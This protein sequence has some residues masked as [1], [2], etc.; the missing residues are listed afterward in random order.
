[1]TPVGVGEHH[2]SF[3]QRHTVII[4]PQVCPKAWPET[5]YGLLEDMLEY[6][7]NPEPK[8]RASIL[9]AR[10]TEAIDGSESASFQQLGMRVLAMDLFGR[11]STVSRWAI[12]TITQEDSVQPLELYVM[13]ARAPQKVIDEHIDTLKAWLNSNERT[14]WGTCLVTL[15][16]SAQVDMDDPIAQHMARC[17]AEA[18]PPRLAGQAIILTHWLTKTERQHNGVRLLESLYDVSN[19][20][21]RTQMLNAIDT[22]QAGQLALLPVIAK[23]HHT[24]SPMV[25]VAMA[26]VCEIINA[27]EA[28]PILERLL[29]STHVDVAHHAARVAGQVGSRRML[30]ALKQRAKAM[31]QK[32]DM[33]PLHRAISDIE[34]RH[35]EQNIEAGALSLSEVPGT[36]GALSLSAGEQGALSIEEQ[37]THQINNTA[38][39]KGRTNET[40]MTWQGLASKDRIAHDGVAAKLTLVQKPKYLI[41]N[42]IVLFICTLGLVIFYNYAGDAAALFGLP[43]LVIGL[44]NQGMLT[45][46]NNHAK[47]LVESI[48]TGTFALASPARRDNPLAPENQIVC[49]DAQGES[50]LR[51]PRSMPSEINAKSLPVVLPKNK[52]DDVV[53]LS[54]LPLTLNKQG[55][56]TTNPTWSVLL[57]LMTVVTTIMMLINLGALALLGG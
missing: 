54:E 9:A 50:H 3:I 25:H 49:T 17:D 34:M 1:M 23:Q 32:S 12:K 52:G 48:D 7:N 31:D 14:N 33:A 21:Q 19:A 35:P 8:S 51:Q 26:R 24:N 10:L 40:I 39:V 55:Q 57:F 5:H 36:S 22:S 41:I 42:T 56:L 30:E 18:L 13:A 20:F 15:R 47:S 53:F 2:Y 46:K 45:L 4:L 28:E 37:I 27:P 29:N 11:G 6:A 43:G 44:A 16:V 38:M